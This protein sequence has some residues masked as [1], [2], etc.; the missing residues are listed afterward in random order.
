MG[1]ICIKGRPVAKG[2]INN[3]KANACAFDADRWF[4]TGDIGYFDEDGYF[5]FV[6]RFK[7]IIK[8]QGNQ[9]HTVIIDADNEC[10]KRDYILQ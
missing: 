9:V 4:L 5:Y 7:N 3:P 6:D 1:E 8:Y 10:I 2:Y